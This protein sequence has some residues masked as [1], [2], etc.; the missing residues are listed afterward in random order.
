MGQSSAKAV[1]LGKSIKETQATQDKTSQH[2]HHPFL[3]IMPFPTWTEQH[4]EID[5][6]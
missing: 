6:L 5:L 4:F 1:V 3:E 2:D